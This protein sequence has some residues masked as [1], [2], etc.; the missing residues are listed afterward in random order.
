MI[1]LNS[2][3]VYGFK[4]I[5][6]TGDIRLHEINNDNYTQNQE[7]EST[8]RILLEM[9]KDNGFEILDDGTAFL[10]MCTDN[11]STARKTARLVVHNP[12]LALNCVLHRLHTTLTKT[13]S[14]LAV[15]D[16]FQS[17]QNIKSTIHEICN[18]SSWLVNTPHYGDYEKLTR[19][20]LALGK[21]ID[22]IVKNERKTR[23][24]CELKG[25]TQLN[26]KNLKI[27]HIFF[28]SYKIICQNLQNTRC[29]AFEPVFLRFYINKAFKDMLMA[30][31]LLDEMKAELELFETHF[32]INYESKI[33]EDCIKIINYIAA[34]L[35]PTNFF[36]TGKFM[37]KEQ[38]KAVFK[39]CKP[40]LENWDK[41]RIVFIEN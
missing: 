13:L 34:F 8:A 26:F 16:Q 38:T 24:I 7:S 5:T 4:T 10:P 29:L 14:E 15:T 22:T 18:K 11:C 39:K 21:L 31:N 30:P 20:W 37:T 12:E 19:Q 28:E 40:F 25:I 32:F 3:G 33:E 36:V 1:G 2:K 41:L 6:I 9:L 23:E 35:I 17:F 27:Y